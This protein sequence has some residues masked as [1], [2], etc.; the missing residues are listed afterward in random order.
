MFCPKE[1][2]KMVSGKP[3]C[4][5]HDLLAPREAPSRR[6]VTRRPGA[7]SRVCCGQKAGLPPRGA[8]QWPQGTSCPSGTPLSPALTN[9]RTDP[10]VRAPPGTA[11]GAL[12]MP[13]GAPPVPDPGLQEAH[14][15]HRGCPR[16]AS[17]K[18]KGFSSD[19]RCAAVRLGPRG[20][21]VSE[22]PHGAGDL[23]WTLSGGSHAT[24]P[25][26]PP[27]PADDAFTPA[28]V[29]ASQHWSPKRVET[30]GGPAAT[31]LLG[32]S[33]PSESGRRQKARWSAEP[34]FRR[35]ADRM[36]SL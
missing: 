8:A 15:G 4:C 11:H 21:S 12:A 23:P 29:T 10:S 17:P 16:P 7:H 6:C 24:C 33:R 30:G 18:P 13:T 1:K 31:G 34:R 14:L 27:A 9:D 3:Q 2:G 35:G 25:C 28:G 26:G 22:S 20:P 32:S 36:A 19:R 5:L